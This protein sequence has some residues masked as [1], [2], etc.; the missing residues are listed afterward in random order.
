[1][2][3]GWNGWLLQAGVGAALAASASF[4]GAATSTAQIA[5]SIVAPPVRAA[6]LVDAG[7]IARLPEHVGVGTLQLRVVSISS[8]LVSPEPQRITVE[9]N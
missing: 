6:A 7:T 4:A 3:L 2:R 8:L 1:M 5:V 9:F